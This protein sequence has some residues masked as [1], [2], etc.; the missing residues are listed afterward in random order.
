MKRITFNVL[1]KKNN[2]PVFETIFDFSG[3]SK[4]KDYYYACIYWFCALLHKEDKEISD[5]EVFRKEFCDVIN[6]S[7]YWAS[8]EQ[9]EEM[10]ELERL[11][12]VL[13]KEIEKEYI[14][15][16]NIETNE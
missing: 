11:Y 6:I 7:R 2:A 1:N 8:S 15:N 3:N 12:G 14:I 10:K 13:I 4:S 16:Y 9:I 5:K